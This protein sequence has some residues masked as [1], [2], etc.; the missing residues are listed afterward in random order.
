M[1]WLGGHGNSPWGTHKGLVFNSCPVKGS[2][3]KGYYVFGHGDAD[4][5]LSTGNGG[6]GR[7]EGR[8]KHGIVGSQT[9]EEIAPFCIVVVE[10][11]FL[12]AKEPAD[13]G[14]VGFRVG[15][16]YLVLP[17]G[18]S[19]ILVALRDIRGFYLFL[20]VDQAHI[21]DAEEVD[22]VQFCIGRR[23]DGPLG[24]PRKIFNGGLI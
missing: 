13:G 7:P 11:V 2:R 9:F 19:Q 12:E 5:F 20:V 22:A 6:R 16:D 18:I 21:F 4:E 3:S 15:H 24:Q 23:Q 17:L 8:Y 14:G 1:R 10:D